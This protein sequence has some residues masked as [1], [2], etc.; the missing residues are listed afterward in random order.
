M[1]NSSD[2]NFPTGS[3]TYKVQ[4]TLANT[5]APEATF[6]QVT[7]GVPLDFS[8]DL[9][10]S[11]LNGTR[12]R[13]L[14]PGNN[15]T[16]LAQVSLATTDPDVSPVFNAERL[17][18]LLTTNIINA[19]GIREEQISIT[20]G[21]HHNNAANIIVTI[22]APDL[23]DGT[24]ATANVPVLNSDNTVPFIMVTYPGSGYSL[25]PTV[26]VSEPGA[27]SNATAIAAGEN[28]SIGGNGIARYITRQVTL[29]N[30]MDSG[31][32]R[33]YLSAVRPAGTDICVYY[34][35]LSSVD[36]QSFVNL[37]W[38][39]MAIVNDLNSPD[40]ITPIQLLFC[41]SL[42]PNGLPS[43]KLSYNTGGVQYPLNGTFKFFA[44][45]IV[46]FAD[47]PTVVPSVLSMQTIAYPAG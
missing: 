23:A 17:S 4:T 24:Q 14:F 11:S 37:P 10:V 21:G 35:V 34:K 1:L 16:L 43:G 46:L 9:K 2:M 3:L 36:T 25:A 20:S 6:Q 18:A 29:A 42:G 19:G 8:Q 30:G 47:D 27:S 39:K 31:D 45:K 32:L 38:V 33:V 26:T 7:S 22:S 15:Q 28:T 12:R 40:Q 5:G 44:I 41:P 13:L